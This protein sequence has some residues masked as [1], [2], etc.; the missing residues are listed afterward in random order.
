MAVQHFRANEFHLFIVTI[1]V[2]SQIANTCVLIIKAIITRCHNI[3]LGKFVFEKCSVCYSKHC[4]SVLF[5]EPPPPF[6]SNFN[7][8]PL[9][10]CAFHKRSRSYANSVPSH[11]R[12]SKAQSFFTVFAQRAEGHRNPANFCK[13]G[14]ILLIVCVGKSPYLPRAANF[15]RFSEGTRENF[16]EIRGC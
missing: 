16:P 4:S 7:K 14:R 3:S 12:I 6:P 11:E 2:A 15:L 1:I 8:L 10:V 13:L 9:N 5:T